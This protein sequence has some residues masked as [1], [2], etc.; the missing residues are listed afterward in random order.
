[1]TADGSGDLAYSPTDSFTLWA[2]YEAH[3]GRWRGLTLAGG[4]RY[5]GEMKRGKDGAVG[6]PAYTKSY[7]VMDGMASY[8][9]TTNV[10]AQLNVY[11]LFDADYVAAINK[12]GYRYTP[13]TPRTVR[14]TLNIRY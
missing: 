10:V 14:L 2:A 5:N 8:P 13:G 11:N 6:T 3:H 7:W 4:P 12:S 1:V 9:L